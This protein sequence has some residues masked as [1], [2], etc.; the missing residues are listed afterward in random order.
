MEIRKYALVVE[1]E[2]FDILEVDSDLPFAERWKNGFATSPVG[3]A[4]DSDQEIGIGSVWNGAIFESSSD[5][6]VYTN[7]DLTKRYVFLLN[8][9]VF[10]IT[11]PTLSN[12]YIDSY[13]PAFATG[14]VGKDITDFPD[15]KVGWIFDGDMFKD[16]RGQ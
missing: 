13:E 14:V 4:V 11:H 3:M 10:A 9:V 1:N 16:P 8:N 6:N 7:P 15:V 2:I 12:S 5:V